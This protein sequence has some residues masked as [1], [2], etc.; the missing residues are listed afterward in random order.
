[1]SL[2]SG[3]IVNLSHSVDPARSPSCASTSLPSSCRATSHGRF[4]EY[5]EDLAIR[6]PLSRSSVLTASTFSC[7]AQ[8][9]GWATFRNIGASIKI[10]RYYRLVLSLSILL[11]LDLFFLITWVAL[12]LDQ[13]CTGPVAPF[14]KHRTIYKTVFAFIVIVSVPKARLPSE[15]EKI[16]DALATVRPFH[17]AV[18]ALGRCRLE[19]GPKGVEDRHGLVP[20]RLCPVSTANPWRFTLALV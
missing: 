14:L 19:G 5:A 7:T 17:L 3:L 9:Y 10:N 2:W 6:L 20:G 16:A 1:M 13:L 18:R 12:W 8:L 15:A 11:Q 4:S